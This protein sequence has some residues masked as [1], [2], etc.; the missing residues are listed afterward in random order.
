MKKYDSNEKGFKYHI[1]VA[2]RILSTDTRIKLPLWLV[3]AFKVRIKN[4]IQVPN[5]TLFLNFQQGVNRPTKTDA[6]G[7]EVDEEQILFSDNSAAL[8]KLYL[9]HDLLEEA[10][11]IAM[12]MFK[13]TKVSINITLYTVKV[14]IL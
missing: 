11:E 2:D 10:T 8:L 4:R 3:A 14:L 7:M 5:L 9:K 12:Y 1:A 6:N 13:N